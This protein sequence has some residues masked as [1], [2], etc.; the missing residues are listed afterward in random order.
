MTKKVGSI[1][2]VT[3]PP[4]LWKIFGYGPVTFSKIVNYVRL[5]KKLIRR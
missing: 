5:Y 1:S 2:G 3:C 4:P